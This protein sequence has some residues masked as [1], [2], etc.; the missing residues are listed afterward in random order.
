MPYSLP[1]SVPWSLTGSKKKRTPDP[2]RLK[3]KVLRRNAK[4][5]IPYKNMKE[6]YEDIADLCGDR[7][8]LYF[9]GDRV[10]VDSPDQ[11]PVPDY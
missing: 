10:K 9:P 6:I 11:R 7:V 4:R 3:S 1:V 5:S 8:S 2:G